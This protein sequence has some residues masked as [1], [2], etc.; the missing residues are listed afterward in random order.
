LSRFSNYILCFV[1]VFFGLNNYAQTYILNE[2]FSSASGTTPPNGWSN[3]TVAGTATDLWHFDN[4]GSRTIGFPIIGTYAIFDSDSVS[5]NGGDEEV[6]LISTIL[7]CSGALDVLL[8]FDHYFAGSSGATGKVEVFD[9]TNWVIA[10]TITDSTNG[11]VNKLINISS[12]V[13]GVS[14][15][16]VKFVWSGNS[17]NFWAVD[18]I[19]LYAPLSLDASISA[20]SSPT[21]PFSAGN[22]NIEASLSNTGATTI[23]SATIKWSLDGFLQSSYAWSGNLAI[24]ET[25]N[26]I[27]IANHNFTA[28]L[29]QTLKVWVESPNGNQDLNSLNDFTSN[30]VIASINGVYTLVV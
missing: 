4:P 7:D 3:N 16:R 1:L 19:Q 13:S 21:L 26:N 9:G 29:L 8:Y 5:S 12:Y 30:D 28:G 14:N 15:A 11:V 23:T 10:S 2:D 17:D 22:Y 25:E 24:G 6:E 27:V 18:N 20:I